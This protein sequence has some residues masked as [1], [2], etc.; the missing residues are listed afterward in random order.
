MDN[1]KNAKKS[2]LKGRVYSF[3]TYFGVGCAIAYAANVTGLVDNIANQ[4]FKARGLN[5]ARQGNIQMT[6]CDKDGLDKIVLQNNTEDNKNLTQISTVGFQNL[7]GKCF[8]DNLPNVKP[9]NYIFVAKL[10]DDHGNVRT[11]TREMNVSNKKGGLESYFGRE[12]YIDNKRL[13][14][15]KEHF[16]L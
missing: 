5:A 11:E 8:T 14:G 12:A 4:V 13:P 2:S 15:G 9:G 10:M 3:I 1:T 16:R 7:Y 6:F